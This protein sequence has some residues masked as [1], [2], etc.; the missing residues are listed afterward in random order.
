M[1][2]K[3][4]LCEV[5]HLSILNHE[6]IYKYVSKSKFKCLFSQIYLILCNKSKNKKS[7]SNSF[8]KYSISN[9]VAETIKKIIAPT[10]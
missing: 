1:L 9:C 6:I 3:I 7:H 4:V 10:H 5:I 8:S 2:I